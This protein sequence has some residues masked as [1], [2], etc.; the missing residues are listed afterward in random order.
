MK[1]PSQV[2]PITASENTFF[3]QK[4]NFVL[5]RN[6]SE[7]DFIVNSNGE[8]YSNK[9]PNIPKEKA[10]KLNQKKIAN[11]NYITPMRQRGK[12]LPASPLC[13]QTERS[14]IM[15]NKNSNKPTD[16]SPLKSKSDHSK[17]VSQTIHQSN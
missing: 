9:N 14:Q 11:E 1:S 6:T 3:Y 8:V 17:T 10:D 15:S 7:Q 4:D 13:I 12:A 16:D 2:V 5:N